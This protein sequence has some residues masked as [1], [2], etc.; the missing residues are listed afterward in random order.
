[1]FSNAEGGKKKG[2]IFFPSTLS[3]YSYGKDY[4]GLRTAWGKLYF[5][6]TPTVPVTWTEDLSL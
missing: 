3:K 1:M 6:I 2:G 5:S 4:T